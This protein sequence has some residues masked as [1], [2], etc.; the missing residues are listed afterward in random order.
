ME[1]NESR[2][3]SLVE[4]SISLGVKGRRVTYDPDPRLG[5]PE[6]PLKPEQSV[7]LNLSHSSFS[8][9]EHPDVPYLLHSLGSGL[10]VS[11][12][13]LLRSC[14][15]SLTALFIHATQGTGHPHSPALKVRTLL[16]RDS[17]ASEVEDLELFMP[18]GAPGR[19][20]ER[21]GPW[22]PALATGLQGLAALR[23]MSRG[24]R[25]SVEG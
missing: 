22:L 17:K 23:M 5:E 19:G 8:T 10:A 12:G 11:L 24:D 4:G 9:L 18:E 14:W 15:G 6:Q 7:P 13:P 2:M 20:R 25:L 16:S 3:Q 21:S 1:E